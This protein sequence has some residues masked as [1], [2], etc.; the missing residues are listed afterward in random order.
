MN[1]L[2]SILLL[3]SCMVFVPACKAKVSDSDPATVVSETNSVVSSERPTS[4]SGR[5]TIE[6][7]VKSAKA[8]KG[9]G[10][11]AMWA[12]SDD[13]TTIYLYGTIH[14]L[15]P[16]TTWKTDDFKSTFSR[17]DSL[18]VEADMATPAGAQTIQNMVT[19]RAAMPDGKT[20]KTI[21][22]DSQYE[23]FDAAIQKMG[24]PAGSLDKLQPWMIGLQMM[25][26]DAAKHG[27]SSGSGVDQALIVDAKTSGKPI[28]FLESVE[29]Q[30]ELLTGGSFEQQVDSLLFQ[31]ESMDKTPKMLDI[32][33]SEWS[34]GD[35][36]GL[37]ALMGSPDMYGS[38]AQYDSFLKN[39][40]VDWVKKIEAM[41]DQPGTIM[42]AGGAGHFAGPDSVILML[43]KNGHDVKLV[44]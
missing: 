14:I 28:K 33:V 9:D 5:L 21:M 23:K 30:G 16:S 11:P 38:Q 29:L 27:Y 41:L 10:D 42:I 43:E 13:D 35:L 12:L 25:M 7:A 24:I 44:Q 26:R 3:T 19:A 8:S 2:V 4:L 39:R 1:K 34:D 22:N 18:Y 6:D 20:L 36:N 32:L 17:I 31:L 15:K 40:N 37:D